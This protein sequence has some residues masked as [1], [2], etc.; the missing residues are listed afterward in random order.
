MTAWDR[1][2]EISHNAGTNLDPTKIMSRRGPILELEPGSN[3]CHSYALITGNSYGVLDKLCQIRSDR[4]I[5]KSS[6][7]LTSARE[8]GLDQ[9]CKQKIFHSVREA[10]TCGLCRKSCWRQ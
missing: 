7:A 10:M 6:T 9:A 8:L 2:S 1:K 4:F 3:P 5:G